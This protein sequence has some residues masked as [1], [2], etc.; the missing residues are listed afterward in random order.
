MKPDTEV[1]FENLLKNLKFHANLT[2]I[3]GTL[4]E[5]ICT[6]MTIFP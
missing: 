6:F 4:N 3:T 5:D 1:F 2:R